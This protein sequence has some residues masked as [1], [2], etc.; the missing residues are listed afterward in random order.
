MGAA[1]LMPD[2]EG[3]HES[4]GLFMTHACLMRGDRTHGGSRDSRLI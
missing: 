4:W 2:I 1:A 3:G